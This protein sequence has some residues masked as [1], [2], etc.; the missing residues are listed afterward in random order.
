MT[1]TS[2]DELLAGVTHREPM[3]GAESL[4]TATFERVTIDGR[5][6][7]VKYLHCDDDWVMRASGDLTCS[8]LTLWRGGQFDRLPDC[9]DHT[10]VDVA[11][12]LGRNGWGGALLMRDEGAHFVPDGDTII[13]DDEHARFVDH[14]A[15]LHAHFW[16]WRDDLGL[17]GAGNRY[18]MFT[19]HL[20]DIEAGLGSGAQVPTLVRQGYERMAE[21]S[22][23]SHALVQAIFADPG[24]YL[25]ALEATPRTF[26]HADW[27]LGN[28]GHHPDGR[29]ILVDWAFS[30]E[31][32][33]L[34]DL[35]W[36]LG[37]NCRRV[38]WKHDETID[39]YRAAIE[40]RGIDTDGWWDAQLGLS[41][42]GCYL[43]QGWSK[44]LGERDD[45][46]TWWEE[47]ALDAERYL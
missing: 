18:L 39:H 46:L 41:L 25:A 8:P 6:H 42:L 43:Q 38:P 33:G 26:L 27:K 7:I 47:R 21:L 35:A 15:T 32:A 5:P 36:Y 34:S 13:G 24:P 45:E 28:L 31:G 40:R 12:G 30:G 29:T 20:T 3:K 19:D 14:M 22:P 4:S 10:I 17:V 16:G 1:A 23:A 44:T 11:V 2:V 37:V 9:I